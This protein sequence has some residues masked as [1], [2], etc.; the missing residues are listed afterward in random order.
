MKEIRIIAAGRGR[1]LKSQEFPDL[2]A[3]MEC[4]FGEYDITQGGGGLEAHPRLTTDVLYR[5]SDSATTMKGARKILLSLAPRGFSISLS[6]CYNYTQNYS[7]GSIQAKQ[8]T[9]IEE[10][11]QKY[12]Y[13]GHLV[14]E[15]S[16]WL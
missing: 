4:V 10:L 14:L 6:S 16:N 15:L 2:A 9:M 1:K 13:V 12:H 7:Q 5:A 11:M 8:H 3:L